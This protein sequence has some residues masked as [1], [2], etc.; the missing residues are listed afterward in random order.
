M[1][2]DLDLAELLLTGMEYDR[3]PY[4]ILRRSFGTHGYTHQSSLITDL[5]ARNGPGRLFLL[6][7][8]ILFAAAQKNHVHLR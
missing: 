8:Q 1:P 6:H 3:S 7:N 4:S 2:A 5:Y